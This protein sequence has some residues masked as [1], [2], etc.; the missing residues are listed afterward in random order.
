MKI[1]K[2]ASGDR[3]TGEAPQLA[4]LIA[5]MAAVVRSSEKKTT[6]QDQAM[7]VA[8]EA[9]EGLLLLPRALAAAAA[10]ASNVRSLCEYLGL[11][12]YLVVLDCVLLQCSSSLKQLL[13]Q[14]AEEV[15]L[16]AAQ[17]SSQAAAFLGSF[18]L[19]RGCCYCCC[20]RRM[21]SSLGLDGLSSHCTTTKSSFEAFMILWRERLFY[22]LLLLLQ[23]YSPASYDE[24]TTPN[25]VLCYI[26]LLH[27]RSRRSTHGSSP[28]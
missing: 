17:C 16:V 19:R 8:S 4:T 20:C 23:Q 22:R 18:S 25:I 12:L 27:R 5:A 1:G 7:C 13:L 11:Q 28:L 9:V 14:L 6:V 21:A 15:V 10:F 2:H 26:L 3:I 24:E